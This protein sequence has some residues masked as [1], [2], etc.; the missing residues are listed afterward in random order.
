MIAHEVNNLLTPILSYAQAALE[1]D[2]PDLKRK[3]LTVTINN[4]RM[5][6]AMSDRV[7]EISSAKPPAYASVPIR[8][9]IEDALASLCRDLSKDGIRLSLD[10][11]E[12]LTVFADATQLQ[13]IFF[14]LFLNARQAMEG[15]H[16]GRLQVSAGRQGGQVVTDVRNTGEAI[17]AG[18]LPHI[19][20]PFQ[21][22]KHTSPNGRGRCGGLGLSLCRD[23][24]EE[25]DG[26]IAVESVQGQGTTFTITLPAIDSRAP[27]ASH[28]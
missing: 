24:L 27:Q 28:A 2:D 7:L 8:A 6:V 15:T 17:P 11:D 18:L 5:L 9:V 1:K 13:Q 20:E 22:S 4:V 21:T 19:F 23:L 14:N 25:N 26:T 12:S 10:V 3:A 16:S